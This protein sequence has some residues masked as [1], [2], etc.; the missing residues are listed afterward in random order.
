LQLPLIQGLLKGLS[1]AHKDKHQA[2][3]ERIKAVLTLIAK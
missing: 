3:F 2:L 1:V